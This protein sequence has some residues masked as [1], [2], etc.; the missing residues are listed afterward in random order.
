M[1]CQ[2]LYK[3]IWGRT[4]LMKALPEKARAEQKGTSSTATQWLGRWFGTPGKGLPSIEEY[5]RQRVRVYALHR[6][7]LDKKCVALNLEMELAASDAAIEDI[8]RQN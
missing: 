1:D 2:A 6:A 5:E 3:S 7:M 8:R 4:Q